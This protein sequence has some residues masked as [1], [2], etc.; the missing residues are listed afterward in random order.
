MITGIV[1]AAGRSE[2]MGRTKA[3]LEVGGRSFLAA[4]A[5]ALRGGGCEEVVAVVRA[6]AD[7]VARAAEAVGAVV[8]RNGRPDAEPIDSL[9]LGLVSARA[10]A[11]GALVLPV[12]HPLVTAETV[13]HLVAAHRGTPDAVVRPVR[14]G[15]PG[16]PTLFPRTVW[17]ALAQEPLPEGARSV[18]E[19]EGTRRVDVPVADPGV[20]VDIDTPELYRQHARGWA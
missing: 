4:A 7:D 15:R 3:L 10:D 11:T 14:D 16:H 18:V 6:D 19:A 12:D 9:R 13:A 2:R 8:V 17:A 20:L 1:L 5:G